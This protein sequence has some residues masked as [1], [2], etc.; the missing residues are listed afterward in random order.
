MVCCAIVGIRTP[1]ERIAS[2][3]ADRG[4]E[5]SQK[6]R[7]CPLNRIV[8]YRRIYLLYDR[9]Q[10]FWSTRFHLS[11]SVPWQCHEV[12]ELLFCLSGRGQVEVEKRR[13][14]LEP[15]RAILIV[16]G[17]QHR[18]LC[19]GVEPAELKVVCLT[20]ED[21]MNYLSPVQVEQLARARGQG[22]AMSEGGMGNLPAGALVKLIPEG[23]GV[24]S[25]RELLMVW[26]VISLLLAA[27]MPEQPHVTDEKPLQ[28]SRV[29]AICVWLDEHL[30]Q[31]TNLDA[32]AAEFGLSRSLLT[33]IFRRHTGTSIVHYINA[34]RLEK[35]A[36]LLTG[37]RQTS[38][39]EAALESGFANLS[40]FHRRFKAAFGLTPAEFRRVFS[41]GK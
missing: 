4:A 3:I 7:I 34:R 8:L 2:L 14:T 36:A 23:E 28:H 5:G 9:L 38:I 26:S 29:R 35:A 40:H 30:E 37:S 15:E 21:T 39:T 18:L 19:M 11:A 33:R 20:A 22:F 41:H 17:A 1:L 10:M 25:P 6:S 13:L 27:Q 32:I 12:F 24:A 31:E 16:P